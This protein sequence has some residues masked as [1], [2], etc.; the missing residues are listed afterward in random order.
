VRVAVAA[1]LAAA[2]VL[3]GCGGGE[4]PRCVEPDLQVVGD[5]APGQRAVP[6][7][8]TVAVTVQGSGFGRGCIQKGRDPSGGSAAVRPLERV[9]IFLRQGT[10]VTSVARVAAG[11]SL[12]LEVTFGVPPGYSPGPAEVVATTTVDPEGEPLATTELILGDA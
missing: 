12:E 7:D 10:R 9:Q 1:V 4:D 5:G 6:V 3:A 8:G 11:D 2:L